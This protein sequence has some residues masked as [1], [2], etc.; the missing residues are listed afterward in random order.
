MLPSGRPHTGQLQ[1]YRPQNSTFQQKD[2]AKISGNSKLSTS[3]H[4]KPRLWL[5]STISPN[6]MPTITS[7]PDD[8]INFTHVLPTT[9]G[10]PLEAHIRNGAQKRHLRAYTKKK[11][12]LPLPQV[13]WK[14]WMPSLGKARLRLKESYH[15]VGDNC[16]QI[17]QEIPKDTRSTS[18]HQTWN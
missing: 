1:L 6:R 16:R 14:G 8:D 11:R 2:Q 4:S 18:P 10:S 12:W 13:T 7:F 5:S 17:Q 15:G 9:K 3:G